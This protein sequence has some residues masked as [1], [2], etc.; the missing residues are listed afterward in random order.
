MYPEMMRLLQEEGSL[1]VF[2]D[3]IQ[4]CWTKPNVQGVVPQL[5]LEVRLEDVW[6]A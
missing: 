5:S 4:R 1:L 2:S 3:E 6:M